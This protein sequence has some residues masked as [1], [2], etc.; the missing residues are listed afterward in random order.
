M[1]ERRSARTSPGWRRRAVYANVGRGDRGPSW[2]QGVWKARAGAD[3]QINVDT[4]DEC[5]GATD[6][7]G[8][9]PG[10]VWGRCVN[11]R[12]LTQRCPVRMMTRRGHQYVLVRRRTVVM[13]RMVVLQILVHVQQRHR[14]GRCDERRG[15]SEREEATHGAECT[16]SHLT[17]PGIGESPFATL[18][19][20]GSRVRNSSW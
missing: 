3:R 17:R 13:V 19:I 12:T 7:D 8:M 15:D 14:R 5:R 20:T 2:I 10:I 9:S 1:R 4:L 16:T 6:A 11:R 18:R